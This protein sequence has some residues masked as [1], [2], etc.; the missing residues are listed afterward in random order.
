MPQE[1]NFIPN[2]DYKNPSGE[3]YPVGVNGRIDFSKISGNL[4]L[5]NLVEIQTDSYQQFLEKGID[6]VLAD[7]FPIP[8]YNKDMFVEYVSKRFEEPRFTPLEC[9]MGDQTYSS[10][11]KATLRLR[12]TQT[13]E[14]KE[15]EVFMGDIPLMTD[16]GTFIINGS[17]RVI[18]SQIVRSSGAYFTNEMDRKSGKN[19]YKGD[20]I[21]GR[22]T[23]LQAESD[24]RNTLYVRLDRQFKF[25]A[26]ILF[27]AC[28]LESKEQ[29]RDLFGDTE[30]INAT[31][32]KDPEITSSA[33]ALMRIFAKLKPGEPSNH[34]GRIEFLRGNYFDG[35]RYDLG[36][37]GRFKLTQKLGIYNRLPGCVLAET[38]TDENGEVVF[39]KD[40]RLTKEDVQ[41]L[42]D[43]QY[44]ENGNC[45]TA[46]P[47]IS[48]ID[49]HN[50][51]N[52]VKVYAKKKLGERVVNVIGTD[53]HLEGIHHLTISDIVAFFSY[54]VN[55]MDGIGDSDDIDHLGNRRIRSVGELL[56][57][58]FRA[59]LVKMIKTVQQ[60]MSTSDPTTATPQ[61][62]IN[63]RPL[64]SALREFF[65]S[66][67]LSQFMD[68]T[69]PLAELT[70]KRRISALG[71]GGISR[72][73]ASMEVRDVHYTHYGR[74]C[75]IESPEGQNIGLINNLCTYAKINEY[76]FIMT[77]YRQVYHIG[78]K[79]YVSQSETKYL[80]ADDE[81]GLYVAEANI[82]LSAP[83]LRKDI[84][85]TCTTDEYVKE[86]LGKEIVVRH[87][88]DNLEV[89]PSLVEFVDVSPKQIVSI[90]AA[91]IP[92][93]AHDD[94]TRALMGANMQR[95]ALPLLR[96]SI[97]YVGTGM[98][99]KIAKDSGLAVVAEKGGEVLYRDSSTIVIDDG[100]NNIVYNDLKKG[101]AELTFAKK[102]KK[103]DIVKAG[104]IMVGL[105][106]GCAQAEKS[107]VVLI[108]EKNRIAVDDGLETHFY[109]PLK[110]NAADL[111]HARK[112]AVGDHVME[113]EVVLT[114]NGMACQIQ[115]EGIVES[116]SAKEITVK[117]RAY[118]LQKFDRSNGGTCINQTPIVKVGDIVK[119]DS[120]IADGPA[121]RNGE[122]ALGQNI[123]IAYMTWN[124]FNYEDAI[125]MSERMVK[126]DTFTSIHI[127][128][129]EIE[130]RE[131]KNGVEQITRDIPNVGEDAKAFLDER[132]IIIPG[133]EVKEG[134]ILVGK[135]TPKS[136]EDPG[137]EEK[138][139]AAIFNEKQKDN[140]DT[141]LRV[142][143]G[144]TGIVHAVKV[145]SRKNKDP[146]PAGVT[147]VVR[148]Y[149]VQKRKISE[150]DKMSGR[151]GNK[152]VISKI[153]PV[154][155][156]PFLADGTPIDIL[157]SPMGVPSRMNIGQIFEVHLGLACRKL[158][159]RVATPAFDGVSNEE[160]FDLM[161][162]A[163]ISEDGKT[164]LYDGRTGEPF[165]E[166]ISVG[167]Q[168][169]IKLVHM[170]DDKLHARATGPYA[171]VTQQ[172]LGGKAQNGGQRFG[173]MEVWALEAYGAAH[174]LQEMMTIKS[175]DRVGRVRAYEA[176]IKGL[177]IP[178]PG[179]PE[180][181]KV[182][183]KEL[184]GLCLDVKLFDKQGKT[185]D[186]D[187]LAKQSLV[188]ERKTNSAIHKDLAPTIGD[189][190]MTSVL[191][192][193]AAEEGLGPV[194]DRV[195]E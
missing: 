177:P 39:P 154:E 187:E 146:L 159:M 184:K 145:F 64:S 20:L 23:W 1:D 118:H 100:T 191:A 152:G 194:S 129:Y 116:V 80:S 155:D 101:A 138:L 91:C 150:G 115:V 172:P 15:A 18:I 117:G 84:D 61:S 164:V 174:T 82:S 96:P 106:G 36:R 166:R 104:D 44:F 90:A 111:P 181:F 99:E 97:P 81:R 107:G 141:S 178:R 9:K 73:R 105:E 7:A 94:A 58:Q 66:G 87:D 25:P 185:I 135:A 176:I 83:I 49:D 14:I 130:C 189:V 114:S 77:P 171:L 26:H 89:D 132:G 32:A 110:K 109:T 165:S 156:M 71:P 56:E 8:N 86:I 180:A 147:E 186:M 168:Y 128:K 13:G 75:P 179:M 70:N 157:L 148:V 88:D 131:N 103:N 21:P 167:V 142:P 151:H 5:P 46:I 10:K 122:L 85:P 78:G 169:M 11:L 60:K 72:D 119:D 137:P 57:N 30:F 53:L 22:G 37:P 153:L 6:E 16:S 74:I 52:I 50:V 195:I 48:A 41:K 162:K 40:Y 69:N 62:L 47:C 102:V 63:I 29:F 68:Q 163:H 112:V 133:A 17:E 170:V 175:D 67:Q 113:K 144:G 124:G 108:N 126:D 76:G 140:K 95:Q 160:V 27:M 127:E 12:S 65:A 158:K 193:Q 134:D 183:T 136:A 123:L 98:E 19:L 28:G 35:K 54:Y 121:M 43:M 51:V 33:T 120:V 125:I 139:L 42:R 161:R 2:T 79:S 4:A 93:L 38:L 34:E 190:M 3:S 59:G 188:E 45:T 182:F 24:T 192:D 149:V 55:L 143:H 31:L 92:F 173:E